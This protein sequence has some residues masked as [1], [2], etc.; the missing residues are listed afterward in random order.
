MVDQRSV[1][2]QNRS[3]TGSGVPQCVCNQW[4]S[5][6]K[7]DSAPGSFSK[8]LDR[9]SSPVAYIRQASTLVLV[10][11]VGS[12]II[13]STCFPVVFL[14]IFAFVY[15]CRYTFRILTCKIIVLPYLVTTV[16]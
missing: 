3:S 10:S 6:K 1:G 15:G 8:T 5:I 13:V 2:Q 4:C 9:K 14:V 16:V 12:I 7:A 11:A